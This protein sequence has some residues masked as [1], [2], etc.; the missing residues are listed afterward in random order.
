MLVERL[1]IIEEQGLY[2]LQVTF[3]ETNERLI[4]TP[5]SYVLSLSHTG[6][7][8]RDAN[9]KPVDVGKDGTFADTV[10]AI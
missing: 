5:A 3:T 10:F 6:Q 4:P 7:R 1:G 8:Q 2:Q 9:R